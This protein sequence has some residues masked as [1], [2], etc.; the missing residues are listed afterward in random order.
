VY[1]IEQPVPSQEELNGPVFLDLMAVDDLEICDHVVTIPD[2]PGLSVTPAGDY[3]AAYVLPL[4][5]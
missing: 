5:I 4:Q 1:C 2:E 3:L